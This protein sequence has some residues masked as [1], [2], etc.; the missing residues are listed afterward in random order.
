MFRNFRLQIV[1]VPLFALAA[2]LTLAG[3][4]A[5]AQVKPF[6]VT[7]GGVAAKGIPAVVGMP[8]PH[9]AVGVATELGRYHG[10]G[11]VELL[12]FTSASTAD[13]DSGVPFVFT[14]ANGDKL[15]FTYGVVANG[16]KQ[17]GKVTL[18]PAGR[19]KVT[20]RFV[21]EFNPVPALCTGRFQRVTGGSFI[22]VAVTEPFV[23][24]ATNPVRYTWSGQG[25]I[26]FGMEEGGGEGHGHDR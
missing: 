18:S 24:G 4:R 15:A 8:L 3:P 12:R 25:S 6:R 21:A 5:E 7:G 9:T 13:F 14:A 20:A 16:A 19:G 2:I 11:M 10:V 1:V 26:R 17:A 22:M 23:F